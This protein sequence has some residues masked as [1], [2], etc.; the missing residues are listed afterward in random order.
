[1]R[2][3][4]GADRV[5]S[6]FNFKSTVKT[7]SFVTNRLILHVAVVKVVLISD[8]I[9]VRGC[10]LG[11]VCE[12]TFCSY[13]EEQFKR[14]AGGGHKST[15]FFSDNKKTQTFWT[16]WVTLVATIHQKSCKTTKKM[17]TIPCII[18]DE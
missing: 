12:Y 6:L 14:T 17:T 5:Q 1:M 10:L 18:H 3:E 8:K 7:C 2:R 16:Y 13:L 15:D 11:F 9:P 4:S